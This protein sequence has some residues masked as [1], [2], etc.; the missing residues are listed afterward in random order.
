MGGL[1]LEGS[2]AQVADYDLL[3]QTLSS[4]NITTS[5]GTVEIRKSSDNA[6]VADRHKG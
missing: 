2:A 4:Q 3:T 5:A 6:I 1:P